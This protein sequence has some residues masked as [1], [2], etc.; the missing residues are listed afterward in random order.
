MAQSLRE[1]IAELEAMGCHEAAAPLKE[2]LA[3]IEAKMAA[4]ESMAQQ[5]ENQIG[6]YSQ[7]RSDI[8]DEMDA[9]ADDIHKAREELAKCDDLTGSD[10]D[11][12]KRLERARVG[13]R[14]S[15]T[16]LT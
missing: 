9:L 15:V 7:R 13:T 5:L 12:A 1:K 6:D 14:R 10:Q 3:G 8:A 16:L 11:V 2:M 4:A